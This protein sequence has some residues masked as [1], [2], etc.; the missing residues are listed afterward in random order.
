MSH[1]TPPLNLAMEL[2]LTPVH[3]LPLPIEHRASFEAQ[4]RAKETKKLHEQIKAQI[5][6]VNG[7]YR[8]IVNKHRKRLA[9][10][11]GNLVWFHIRKKRFHSRRQNKLMAHGDGPFKVLKRI[12]DNACKS[13]LWGD[14]N[15][16]AT[17]NVHDLF[18]MSNMSLRI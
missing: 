10:N 13:E 9:F 12:R 14:M 4:K 17:F 16:S 7:S 3:L 8:A 15:V 18:L 1:S 2:S 6:K 5:E 11:L